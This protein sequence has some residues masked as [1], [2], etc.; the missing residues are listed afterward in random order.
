MHSDAQPAEFKRGFSFWMVYVSN[1]V[2][3]ML[4]ALD[5]VSFFAIC[6]SGCCR[7]L[8]CATLVDCCSYRVADNSGR[9]TWDGLRVGGERLR[10]RVHRRPPL[11]RQ[12]CVRVREKAGPPCVHSDVR[13]RVRHLRR[14]A[15]HE[16]AHSWTKSVES[17]LVFSA[18]ADAHATLSRPGFRRRRVHCDHRDYLCGLGSSS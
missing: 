16:H 9:T 11:H 13:H 17:V 15:E 14:R 4:S 8:L 5:L 18:V 12:P 3:D 10:H 7:A 1:L 6:A 2:V